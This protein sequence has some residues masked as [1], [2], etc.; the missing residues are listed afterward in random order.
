[1]SEFKREVKYLVLKLNDIHSG[2]TLTEQKEL[3]LLIN[4]TIS[5]RIQ[6]GK[7]AFNNYVVVN[8]D[9][10]YAETVYKLI[11]FSQTHTEEELK[12]LLENLEVEF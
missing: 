4:K 9:E 10:L 8:K 6:H 1:V 3:N 7:P 5:H 2:L 12:R 11:E